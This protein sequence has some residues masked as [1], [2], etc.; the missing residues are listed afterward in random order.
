MARFTYNGEPG[1][2]Y[3]VDQGPTL[4]FKVPKQDGT[5]QVIDAPDQVNGFVIGA[6]IGVDITDARSLRLMRADSRFSE[7]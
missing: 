2:D 7:V 5:S 6:D 3:V 4:Q 1:R